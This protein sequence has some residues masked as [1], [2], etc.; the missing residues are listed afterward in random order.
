[1]LGVTH[2]LL[3]G[4]MVGVSA[5]ALLLARAAVLRYRRIFINRTF[6]FVWAG[7][8][9]LTG[10]ALFGVWALHCVMQLS[11]LDLRTTVFRAV[12]TVALFPLASFALGRTQ[13]ALMET[14]A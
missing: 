7:F 10:G 11:V 13:R 2:D 8:T 12:A 1:M 6:P 9:V 14:A 3:T 5:L 4:G